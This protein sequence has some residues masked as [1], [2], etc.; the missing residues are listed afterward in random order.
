[1]NSGKRTFPKSPSKLLQLFCDPE[2]LEDVEGDLN[3][4]FERRIQNNPKKATIGAWLDVIKLFRPG[5]I[6]DFPVFENSN[7]ISMLKN[8]FKAAWR[9]MLKHKSFSTI[10]LMSLAIGIAACMVI[11]L[12]IQDEKSFDS[13]HTKKD[14]LYRLCEIQSFPGTNTQHVA[15]TMPGM[16]PTLYKEFPEVLDFTRFWTFGEQ[17]VEVGEQKVMTEKLVGVDSSFFRLF[18]FPIIHGEKNRMIYEK[19]HAVITESLARKVFGKVDVIGEEFEV[20]GDRWTINAVIEDIPEN[21]HLQFEMAVWTYSVKDDI[22]SFDSEFRGNYMNTYLL[23]TSSADTEDMRSRFPDFLRR[24]TGNEDVDDIYKLYLQPFADVH[25]TSSGIEHDYNNYRKF[26]G[27]Y[28]DVF[29][30][31]GLLILIIA[32]VNFTNLTTARAANRAKEVGVRKSI[33]AFKSQLV[34]QF[35]FESIMLAFISLFIAVGLALLFLPFLNHLIDRQLSFGIFLDPILF[36]VITLTVLGL[37]LIAGLYPSFYLSSFEPVVVLK[38]INVSE[39]KSY[40][41]SAL[42][43]VQFSLA[44]AMI[45][46]TLVVTQQLMFIKSKDIGFEKDHIMLISMNDEANDKYDQLKTALLKESNILGVAGSGQRLGNNFHQWGFKAKMDS[47]IVN[48]TPS[49]VLVDY[50]YLDVYGI[51][52]VA[53]RDFSKAYAADDGLSFIINESFAKELGFE[54]PIGRK[55]GHDFYP[56]DSLGTIIGVTEDFHFNSLHHKVNTL[57]MVIH[58]DWNFNEISVKINGANVAQSIADVERVYN[59][60]VSKYPLRYEFLD[61]HISELYKADDQMGSVVSIMAVL[62]IFIGC[63]GLF[64]LASIAIKRRIK[65]IGIR[66]VMGASMNQLMI[67]L[68]KSFAIMIVIAF[69][70]ATPLTYLFLTRWLENFAYRVAINP[71]VFVIGIVLALSIAMLTISFHVIKAVYANPVKSLQYE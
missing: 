39:K 11:Y 69:V 9:N 45:V 4:L 17:L 32:A 71:V 41:R 57:S 31:I 25:L 50:D 43:V 66:K 51:K 62:S 18:D 8:Y 65:E 24:A 44:L 64:G 70:M 40:L 58:S 36:G 59:A 28:L 67:L 5:I 37:G 46:S 47:G 3:E 26:N 16:G 30:L 22:K 61:D 34:Y 20:D 19:S 21:A 33:G 23:L 2:I 56:N 6:K 15:L 48:I 60:F 27:E 10:N 63:M 1:M 13:F 38:G 53:G 55:V 52:L 14:E 7:S 12:F 49:N 42:V 29:V 35:M 68:S 54:D